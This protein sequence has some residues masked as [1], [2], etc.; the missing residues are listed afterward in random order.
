MTVWAGISYNLGEEGAKSLE[1]H[2]IATLPG[3]IHDVR[4]DL[5]DFGVEDF[6]RTYEEL[7]GYKPD[8]RN[9]KVRF[10]A[11]QAALAPSSEI[12]VETL[13]MVYRG[14]QHYAQRF[15]VRTVSYEAEYD[16]AEDALD[17]QEYEGDDEFGDDYED[18]EG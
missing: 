3:D 4:E 11:E 5:A 13:L 18:Y 8:L 1:C 15:P 14:K 7:R 12:Q 16:F 17:E 9:V 2:Y 10:E 6:V